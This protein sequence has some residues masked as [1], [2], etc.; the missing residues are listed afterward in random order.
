MHNLSNKVAKK[1]SICL[2]MCVNEDVCR[3]FYKA[4]RAHLE[5][6]KDGCVCRLYEEGGETQR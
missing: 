6:R 3:L 5:K 2:H 4:R 1:F